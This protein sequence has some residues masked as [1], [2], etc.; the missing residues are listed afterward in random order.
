MRYTNWRPLPL[1]LPSYVGAVQPE[2]EREERER[3]LFNFNSTV[4]SYHT[5]LTKH[6]PQNR[7]LHL[8]GSR[9]ALLFKTK[10]FVGLRRACESIAQEPSWLPIKAIVDCTCTV[11]RSTSYETPIVVLCKFAVS[12]VHF[13]ITD[14]P[15]LAGAKLHKLCTWLDFDVFVLSCHSLA[16]GPYNRRVM[17]WDSYAWFEK[18]EKIEQGVG[19]KKK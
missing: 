14:S 11:A 9:F 3:I 5:R 19:R 15:L 17:C 7:N 16:V 13:E 10:N 2:K 18:D 12:I 6:I 8:T 1:P 4:W